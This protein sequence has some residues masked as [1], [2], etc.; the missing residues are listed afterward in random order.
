MMGDMMLKL[1][2]RIFLLLASL[3]TTNCLQAQEEIQYDCCYNDCC[4]IVCYRPPGRP[5]DC[6]PDSQHAWD[7]GRCGTWLPEDPVLFRPFVADPRQ[8]TY[9]VGWR[10]N[11]NAMTKNTIPVSFWD[12]IPF[13]RWFSV[14]PYC[15]QLQIDL[16]GALWACFDPCTESAPLIN[17][18]YYGGLSVTYAICYWSFRMRFFHISSHIGD[19][20]LLNHPRFHRRNPS[21]ETLDFYFS[22]DLTEDIRYYGGAA[23]VVHRD[24]TYKCGRYGIEGGCEVRLRG[25][26]FSRE[27]SNVC[28]YPYYGMHFRYWNKMD[29]HVDQTYVLGYEFAKFY[30]LRRRL[31][32]FIEYHDGYSVEGQFA[33][34]PTTYFSV[35]TSYGY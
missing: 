10:F 29:K 22:H 1:K 34:K 28:G 9:S 31:R 21:A 7:C 15:G 14:W 33:C 30:G 20:Y 13:Y 27:N 5:G 18:D 12:T 32:F 8:L 23:I 35:R 16:E 24:E 19:E 11:D 6:D 17:A 3:S 25:F 26:G 4:Q 2:T